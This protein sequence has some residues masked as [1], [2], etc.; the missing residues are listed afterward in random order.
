MI[1]PSFIQIPA[2]KLRLKEIQIINDKSTFRQGIK[3]K[4]HWN[5]NLW[6]KSSKINYKLMRFCCHCLSL[7][8]YSV[9]SCVDVITH[10]HTKW[11]YTRTNKQKPQVTVR[12]NPACQLLWFLCSTLRWTE[13]R[14]VAGST[15]LWASWLYT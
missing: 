13:D 12:P 6:N 10:T 8:S 3:K 7:C 5:W 4:V 9:W 2:E 15:G 14:G 1:I 11:N